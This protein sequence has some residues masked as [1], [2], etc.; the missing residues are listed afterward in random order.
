[1]KRTLPST[2]F[3]AL[4]TLGL[5]AA[6]APTPATRSSEVPRL[7]RYSG[8]VA[9][10]PGAPRAGAVGVVFAIYAEQTG[11]APLWV[12]TQ[13]VQLD[14]QG[15][16][17]V[18]LGAVNALPNSIFAANEARWLGVQVLADSA[19]EQPRVM[20][21]S[22]PYALKAQDTETLGGRP[23]SAYLLADTTTPTGNR[24]PARRGAA[25]ALEVEGAVNADEPH[26]VNAIPKFSATNTL[27]D[28][29]MF[30]T[31]NQAAFDA[32]GLV[33]PGNEDVVNI[34]D[35]TGLRKR[36]NVTGRVTAESFDIN[37]S[38]LA[39]SFRVVNDHPD[40]RAMQA[41]ARDGG[42]GFT[43]GLFASAKSNNAV[44]VYAYAFPPDVPNAPGEYAAAVYAGNYNSE[45]PGVV[46][47]SAYNGTP[48]GDTDPT[49]SGPMGL[50]AAV[51][52][53]TGIAAVLDYRNTGT[54]QLLS[55]RMNGTE[56]TSLNTAG[57]FTTAGAI[58][59]AS[60]TGDGSGITGVSA[61]QLDGVAASN[62]ARLDV[63]T[64]QTLTGSLTLP[65]MELPTT[66]SA[67]SGVLNMDGV[68]FLHSGGG[69]F[70]TFL[71]LA[72]GNFTNTADGNTG[73]GTQALFSLTAGLY[74]TATGH[75][76][77]FWN[78]SGGRNT[79]TG[80]FA[81]FNSNGDHN[82]ATGFSALNVSSGT[83]NS[84][85]GSEAL[86]S[87]STGIVN[88]AAGTFAL[89]NN[90]SGSGNTAVG[91][92]AGVTST[93]TNA[94][95]TG[96]NNTFVGYNAG[97]GTSTQLYN[98]TAIGSFALVSAS[99][100]LV[101]GSGV[102]VG[103]G[104]QTPSERLQVV[105]NI[106]AS[107]T[108]TASAFS[109][110]AS[111]ATALGGVAA[112]NYARLD[113][114]SN[115]TMT[116][117]LT[118]PLLA[119]PATSSSTS[120]V[121]TLGGSRFVHG[122]GFNIFVGTDAG[123]FTMSGAGN[124]GIGYQALDS[125]TTGVFN[126]AVGWSTL[127]ANTV[128]SGNT[129][130]GVA[131]LSSATTADDNTAI[132]YQALS[133]NTTG[134]GNTATGSGALAANTS[135]LRN[136]A[137]GTQALA[138]ATTDT[139]NTATGYRALRT[140]LGGLANTAHGSDALTANTTGDSNTAVGYLALP[141]NTSGSSNTA[142][143]T[144]AGRTS[145]LANANT[146]GNNNTFLGFN[147][148]PGTST[149]LTNATAVG[150]N[151]LVSASN[152]LVLGSSAVSVGIGTS[153]PNAKLHVSGGDVAITTQS[154]GVILRATNGANCYRLTVNNA[155]TLATTL[156][157]CP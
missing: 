69:D 43:A 153:A 84:A 86:T 144:Q 30:E 74:N 111:N 112:A 56:V 94:N 122:F 146:T 134:T 68:S 21:V 136:T 103:I 5:H 53:S 1:M 64:N 57:D 2:V 157:T 120:G 142:V 105:G 129:A 99:N 32:F 14:A 128:G 41:N 9:A 143:G 33:I 42:N 7:L 102:N 113:V 16:Y 76:A 98:A 63:A 156:V 71:G 26:T 93:F 145:T 20:L 75:W 38:T 125:N 150:A 17:T 155:G 135:G 106:L 6:Q 65:A 78:T 82:T 47:W 23:A 107:G 31:Y 50:Y 3:C 40:A 55:A 49:L 67:T 132:G 28:S 126:T 59:A 148:G 119:L 61:A 70:N 58:V 4:L 89:R 44:G 79:A 48:S 29:L 72:A 66:T 36:L 45:G 108:I 141:S 24:A 39:N 139:D 34:G 127:T 154:N 96:D 85:H 13:N 35:G 87:N 90:T 92:Q 131:A 37:T 88:T 124:I 121:L 115:Q 25:A 62:F 52:H 51:A 46:A 19:P 133:F 110:T 149:Q 118:T 15:R 116:G 101:L 22:V 91:Y 77:L 123:N 18:N 83:H 152:A 140:N 151:A 109:G 73:I 8:S 147:S 114:A 97:P 60:F 54:G 27:D 12:E 81:L 130:L 117:S 95:T 10:D 11:G 137:H 104:T 100:S 138:A 80:A